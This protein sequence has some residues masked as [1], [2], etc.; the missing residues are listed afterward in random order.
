MRQGWFFSL[1]SS[2]IYWGICVVLPDPVEPWI[3]TILWSLIALR[4]RS[5]IAKI[6]KVLLLSWILASALDFDGTVGAFDKTNGDRFSC[7]IACCMLISHCS[8]EGHS[9]LNFRSKSTA[10]ESMFIFT[11]RLVN[12]E[13]SVALKSE[14]FRFSS[15]T[16]EIEFLISTKIF[17][18]T[19]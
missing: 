2:R 17:K 5:L 6:G 4:M 1:A 13:F 10:D 14:S 9:F 8:S 12:S 16:S 7:F 18:V 11:L 3:K 19:Y 15:K